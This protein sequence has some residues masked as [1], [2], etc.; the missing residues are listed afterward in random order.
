MSN[1]IKKI[2]SLSIVLLI[3]MQVF[4]Q[5]QKL[6]IKETYTS[7]D[8]VRSGIALGGIGT[9]GI[10]L[11][12]DGN[13]YNWSIFNNYPLGSGPIFELS[14]L[15]KKSIDQSFL[16]F[17]VRYQVEGQK[18]KLKLLQLNNSLQEGG[19]E[20]IIYYY[21]WMTGV[22]KIEYAA[23]FPFV[24]MTFADPDMPFV[25]ELEAFSPFI[26]HDVKNSS[27]PG[28]YFNYKIKSTTDKKVD[29]MLL[30]T[31]R[32]L[33]GYDK[34][35]KTFESKLT[36]KKEYTFF[37]HS[38]SGMDQTASSYGQMGLGVIGGDEISYYLGWEHKHPYYEKLLVESKLANIDDTP[39]RNFKTDNGKNIGRLDTH[40]NDQRCFSS[41]AVSHQFNGKSEFATTF[42]MNWNFPNSYGAI[43][44]DPDNSLENRKK[45]NYSIN[46]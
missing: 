30:G 25:V 35:E 28:I 29:V 19:L 36:K 34:I 20:A 21:P 42:F 17:L 4:S 2:S 41:I 14:S 45:T 8:R 33:V 39:N 6:P 31:L 37:A 5:E 44:Q 3:L 1:F 38:V 27:L 15:P 7:S 18:A 11:R 23:R 32:N 12:K 26:P 24:N 10:E 43:S 40:D 9:G 13:F 22:D 16:F 46:L